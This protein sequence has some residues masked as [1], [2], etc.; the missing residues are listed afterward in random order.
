LTCFIKS[1]SNELQYEINYPSS[2]SSEKSLTNE[3]EREIS[4][5]MSKHS[6][7]EIRNYKN[8]SENESKEN[9]KSKLK[10]KEH[11]KVSEDKDSSDISSVKSQEKKA[12]EAKGNMKTI[13][14]LEYVKE[15]KSEIEMLRN[16]ITRLQTAQ[17]TLEKT[18]K[19]TTYMKPYVLSDVPGQTSISAKIS[20]K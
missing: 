10:A 8:Q 17:T 3:S 14:E 20:S 11:S 19:E 6:L 12:Q 18:L 1:Q 2:S 7:G 13:D 9:S 15:L 16:E 4:S 5:A